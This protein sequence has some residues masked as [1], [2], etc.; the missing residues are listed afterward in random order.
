MCA[1]AFAGR[2]MVV[3]KRYSYLSC[4]ALDVPCVR[5]KEYERYVK[6]LPAPA[7]V[8]AFASACDAEC[9]R[10]SQLSRLAGFVVFCCRHARHLAYRHRVAT[11]SSY[12]IR[13]VGEK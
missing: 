3:R 1:F 7:S 9:G 5:A 10:S 4:G 11:A 13:P 2:A 8:P 6:F 12:N